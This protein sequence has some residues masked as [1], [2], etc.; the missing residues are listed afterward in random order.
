[1]SALLPFA[2]GLAAGWLA[3]RAWARHRRQ[4]LHAEHGL[5]AESIIRRAP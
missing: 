2:C 3:R 1:M 5:G 4:R